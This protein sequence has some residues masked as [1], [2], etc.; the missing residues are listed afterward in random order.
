MAKILLTVSIKVSPFLTDEAPDEKLITSAESRFSASS[1]ESF[2]L[3][4]F[5]K[6]LPWKNNPKN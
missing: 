6:N 1:K 2:V 5:S 3:V 4:E